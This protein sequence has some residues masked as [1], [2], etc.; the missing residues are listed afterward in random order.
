[1]TYM[2]REG[3][4]L[5]LHGKEENSTIVEGVSGWSAV[6]LMRHMYV[7]A[8]LLPIHT[9]GGLF[10]SVFGPLILMTGASAAPE[11][12]PRW[13]SIGHSWYETLLIYGPER[14]LADLLSH[15]WTS[16]AASPAGREANLAAAGHILRLLAPRQTEAEME[17][18]SALEEFSLFSLDVDPAAS[19]D[20]TIRRYRVSKQPT[21]GTPVFHEDDFD[22]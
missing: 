15:F 6:P 9:H 2:V 1:M 16:S 10:P 3:E 12:S 17:D 4:E 7:D 13:S 5:R 11:D 20:W 21:V 19:Q 8:G 22:V 18:D 14:R